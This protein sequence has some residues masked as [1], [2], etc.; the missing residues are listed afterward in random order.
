MDGSM[1]GW[2]PIDTLPEEYRVD[3]DRFIVRHKDTGEIFDVYWPADY[4]RMLRFELDFGPS[5]IS[6]H[7]F[8]NIDYV[9]DWMAA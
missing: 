6:M 1:T 4:K 2:Q 5:E 8:V 9:S 7:G 3:G